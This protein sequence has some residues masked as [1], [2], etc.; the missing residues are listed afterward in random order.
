MVGNFSLL[1]EKKRW[2]SVAT[3]GLSEWVKGFNIFF[4]AYN[5]VAVIMALCVLHNSLKQ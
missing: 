3:F 5:N 4:A 2:H 1:L